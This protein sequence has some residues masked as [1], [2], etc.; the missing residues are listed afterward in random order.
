MTKMGLL[1]HFVQSHITYIYKMKVFHKAKRMKSMCK[2]QMA[3]I[4]SR[5][6]D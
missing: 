4:F 6:P 3:G 2:A 1:V 5:G